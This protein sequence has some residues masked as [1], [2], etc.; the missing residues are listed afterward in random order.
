MVTPSAVTLGAIDILVLCTGNICRSPVA[1]A[2]LRHRLEAMGVDAHVHSAGLLQSGNPAHSS[3]IDILWARG[4]DLSAHRSTTMTQQLLTG[5]DLILGMA[6]EH[7][8]EATVLAMAAWPRTFT[9][10]ELV[11]RGE[12]VGPRRHG[13]EVADWLAR[14]HAGRTPSALMG[15]SPDDDI[16][17]PIGLPR[18]VYERVT[19]EIDYFVGRL[20]DLVWADATGGPLTSPTGAGESARATGLLADPPPRG[21]DWR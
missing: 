5:A 15:S 6:R 16:D 18:S 2:L 8:R 11:R 1:E 9:L 7:V 10:K 20:V 14:A 13:E 21:S 19:D 3:G 12:M 4:H 17:D